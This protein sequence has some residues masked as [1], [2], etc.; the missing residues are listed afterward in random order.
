MRVRPAASTAPDRCS[1]ATRAF[2]LSSSSK[3][4]DDLATLRTQVALI[5]LKVLAVAG[6]AV[7]IW[8]YVEQD[9]FRYVHLAGWILVVGGI[10]SRGRLPN[11]GAYVLFSTFYLIG[12]TELLS[13]G[14]HGSH[15][16]SFVLATFFVSALIGARAAFVGVAISLVTTLAIASLLQMVGWFSHQTPP[17]C[18]AIGQAG[19]T[20]I[21]P[22]PCS[23]DPL[24]APPPT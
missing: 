9:P 23:R 3:V 16:E 5:C 10:L 14:I 17:D 11:V 13:D 20:I 4:E 6:A 2:R 22:S 12:I 21:W 7:V 8:S 19:S 15:V 18:P 24:A 1:P